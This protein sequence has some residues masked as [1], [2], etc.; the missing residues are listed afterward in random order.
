M[1]EL[2]KKI[3]EWVGIKDR[4]P[5]FTRSIG[6]CFKY[7]VPKLQEARLELRLYGGQIGG[8]FHVMFVSG[9]SIRA[10]AEA[11]TPALSLCQAVEKLID[12]G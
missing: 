12:G 8:N 11:E 5:H 1:E 10:I 4:A 7:I 9:G 6:L 2:N 3:A